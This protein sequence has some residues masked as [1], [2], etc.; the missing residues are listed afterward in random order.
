MPDDVDVLF[1]LSVPSAFK[2]TLLAAADL[3]I[4]TPL[5]EHFGIVP[6]EA[7]LARTPVLAANEGGPVETVVEGVTGWLRDVHEVEAWT[8]VMRAVLGRVP[9]SKLAEMGDA[10]RKR[11]VDLFSKDK[12]AATL[13]DEINAMDGVKQRPAVISSSALFLAALAVVVA[14]VA[15]PAARRLL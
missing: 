11:V 15:V 12:M 2:T 9:Q 3:L 5:H 8:E 13:D 1:L 10:G 14:V 6:L 7:M 4:Y